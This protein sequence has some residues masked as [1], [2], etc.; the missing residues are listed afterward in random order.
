VLRYSLE[1]ESADH[2]WKRTGRAE[3]LA[4]GQR[5]RFHFTPRADGYLY[6]IATGRRNI[7][8]TFLTAQPTRNA[9]VATNRLA[10]GAEFSFPAGDNS[11]EISN[12][13]T[14]NH[15]TVIFSPTPLQQPAFLTLRAER[16][17]TTTE[18]EELQ[19][20]RQKNG[21]LVPRFQDDAAGQQVLVTVPG[22]RDVTAPLVFD[23]SLKRQ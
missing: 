4:A 14:V 15:F 12:F 6:L 13:G 8:T 5:F 1:V 7:P 18:Q 21:N 20:F 19:A 16:Q 17:L 2:Q 11:I 9:G 22:D 23:I 3:A 10:A